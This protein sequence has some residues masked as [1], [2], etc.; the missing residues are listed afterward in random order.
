MVPNETAF[1]YP[2]YYL[3]NATACENDNWVSATRPPVV[4]LKWMVVG[5]ENCSRPQLN[6][7]CQDN[8]SVCVDDSR[9]RGYQCRCVSGYEGNPYMIGGCKR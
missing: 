5:A 2:L 7:A 4:R 1:S 6:S 3:D 9:V 8:K